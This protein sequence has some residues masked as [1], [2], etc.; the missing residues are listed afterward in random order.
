MTSE[1]DCRGLACPAPVL[2]T[3]QKIEN[4]NLNEINVIVD[5]QA[6]KENVFHL[7]ENQKFEVAVG[8]KGSDF[9]VCGK[10]RTGV[11][12]SLTT[13]MLDIVTAMQLADEVINI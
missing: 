10:R 8:Q 1:L 11:R 12:A 13:N 2:R 9:I 5:N 3:K 6:A 7:L 4:E